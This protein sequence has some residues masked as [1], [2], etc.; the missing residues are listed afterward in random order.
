MTDKLVTIFGTAGAV[1]FFLA[2]G[3]Y[4]DIELFRILGMMCFGCFFISAVAG[5][6]ASETKRKRTR[7]ACKLNESQK[8][9]S[10]KDLTIIIHRVL[11][12]VKAGDELDF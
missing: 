7:R 2:C 4:D 11:G 8:V 5:H 9:G 12:E 1:I 10:N 6:I 3:F